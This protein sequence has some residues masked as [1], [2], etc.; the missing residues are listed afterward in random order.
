[1]KTMIRSIQ[2]EICSANCLS[3]QSKEEREENKTH[4]E[5]SE[6]ECVRTEMCILPNRRF[7]THFP[8]EIDTKSR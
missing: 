7:N 3:K 5:L 2:C 8:N 4:K 1:M 6:L